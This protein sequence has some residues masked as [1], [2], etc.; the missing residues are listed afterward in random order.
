MST[1]KYSC[2]CENRSNYYYFYSLLVNCDCERCRRRRVTSSSCR[3]I[4]HQC[5]AYVHDNWHPIESWFQR[6][7][8]TQTRA[9]WATAPHNKCSH[10]NGKDKRNRFSFWFKFEC[11]QIQCRH[12]SFRRSREWDTC[13]GALSISDC[14]ASYTANKLTLLILALCE[15]SLPQIHFRIW[16]LDYYS[17]FVTREYAQ[18]NLW[19]WLFLY[20]RGEWQPFGEYGFMHSVRTHRHRNHVRHSNVKYWSMASVPATTRYELIIPLFH[21]QRIPYL[22]LWQCI[23]PILFSNQMKS[24]KRTLTLFD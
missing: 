8:E 21:M 15:T 4:A 1:A 13:L 3:F 20:E 19:K 5:T 11:K 17:N 7:G 9:T 16:R 12:A 6:D 24:P 10:R 22:R 2:L 23:W 18:I 14:S